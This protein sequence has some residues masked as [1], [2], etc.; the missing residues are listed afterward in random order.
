M[1]AL[2]GFLVGWSV[3]SRGGQRGYNDVL[4]AAREVLQSDEFAALTAA[5][6]SHTEY[7]LRALADWLQETRE[8]GAVADDL[9]ERVRRLVLPSEADAE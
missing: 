4:A 6:R 8:S 3:G 1:G 9:M 5:V 7:T 2:I